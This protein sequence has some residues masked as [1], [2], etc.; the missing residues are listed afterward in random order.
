[1]NVTKYGKRAPVVGGAKRIYDAVRNF[2]GLTVGT[3]LQRKLSKLAYILF[4]CALGLALVVFKVNKFD[5]TNQ[6]IIYATSLGISIIPESLVTVLTITMV[7]ATEA[8]RDYESER[9]AAAVKFDVPDEKLPAISE[10]VTEPEVQ[11]E[12]EMTDALRA[13]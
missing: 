4:F 5:I 7:I 1:M 9:T 12:V 3:P 10:E 6:V 2:L 8:E 13:F 11:Y